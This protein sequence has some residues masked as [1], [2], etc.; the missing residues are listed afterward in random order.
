[1]NEQVRE[2]ILYWVDVCLLNKSH[3]TMFLAKK[4]KK[5][6]AGCNTE[7]VVGLCI[8]SWR[9]RKWKKKYTFLSG[10]T[11]ALEEP[12]P[13]VTSS[14]CPWSLV[15]NVVYCP[16]GVCWVFCGCNTVVFCAYEFSSCFF[17]SMF[18]FPCNSWRASNRGGC[19]F[20]KIEDKKKKSGAVL[21]VVRVL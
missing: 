7:S 15:I 20:V 12:T 2:Y 3:T 16:G 10:R 17:S 5:K 14:N 8:R 11:T 1:M 21:F 9:T 19:S 13:F 4:K 6:K 18:F